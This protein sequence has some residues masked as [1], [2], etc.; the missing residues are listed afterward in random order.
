MAAL[1]SHAVQSA[2]TYTQKPVDHLSLT[3]ENRLLRRKRLVAA[4][5]TVVMLDLSEVISLNAGDALILEDGGLV[6]VDAAPEALIEVRGAH[7]HRLAWHIGNRHTPCQVVDARLLIKRD[8]VLRD[9]L[10]KLGATVREVCE[11][12]QPEGGAYGHGR[13]HGHSHSH[14]PHEDPNAH[15]HSHE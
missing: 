1:K 9:M 12:F 11:P 3:Y 14:D 13:T 6:R 15:L 8:H 10:V 7:L 5:G 4:H 2:G